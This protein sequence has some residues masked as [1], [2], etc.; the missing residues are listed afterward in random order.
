MKMENNMEK[1]I[2]NNM[3]TENNTEKLGGKQYGY[4][5]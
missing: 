5:K 4:G 3:K 1:S 2:G